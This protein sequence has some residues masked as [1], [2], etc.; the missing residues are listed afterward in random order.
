ML[1]AACDAASPSVADVASSSPPGN[2]PAG[3]TSVFVARVPGPTGLAFPTYEGSGQ[4][5][6]PDVVTF[7]HPWNGH[8]YWTVVTPYPN[9][10]ARFEN[11]S[12]FASD[13]GDQWEVPAG[14]TNPLAKTRRGYLSD[15]DMVYDQVHGRLRLYY[16][17]VHT[18]GTGKAVHHIE[19]NV[20]MTTSAN[21]T[22]W[23]TP[24]L[25]A[26]DSA[27]FVVSPSIVRTPDGEWL[28][29]AVD[30]GTVGCGAH[31][32]QVVE[33]RSRDGVAW[34]APTASGLVQPGYQAWHLDV[35]YVPERSE[36]WA[37]VA[38]Y[39][40]GKSCMVTS[41]FL[42]TSTDGTQWTS[43]AAP[44]LA[45]GEFEPFSKAVYRSTFAYASDNS[46]TVWMS[47]ARTVTPAKQGTPAVLAW[48]AAVTHTTADAIMRRIQNAANAPKL[49]LS[50]LPG[51]TLSPTTSVP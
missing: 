33:R 20:W 39:P 48:T 2:A 13:D 35:Q 51:T 8:K 37:L 1:A 6:H 27:K 28:M 46:V 29:Y 26:T 40:T 43:Y 24:L 18:S 19:D 3:S 16:R 25:V 17:E 38:A 14:V 34:D 10:A 31:T 41:L 42:A 30:A 47:G 36:Y 45:R 12:L 21:S 4:V 15:P 5:V 9:S 23:T 49:P 22:T 7:A 11:P 50:A 32:T 44:V